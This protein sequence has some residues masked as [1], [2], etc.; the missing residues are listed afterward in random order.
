MISDRDNIIAVAGASKKEFLSKRISP[1]LE[2][3][4]EAKITYVTDGKDKPIKLFYEDEGLEEYTAQVITPIVM[5]GDPIGSVILFSK[6]PDITMS[7]L[8]VKTTEIAAGF[9]AKQME[10]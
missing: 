10:N 2:K 5:Q 9:L 3:I 8:E 6:D 7:N 1:E 4:T